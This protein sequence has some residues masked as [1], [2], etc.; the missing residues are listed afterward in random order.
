MHGPN[1]ITLHKKN[2]N[3]YPQSTI[4]DD[5]GK[6]DLGRPLKKVQNIWY[7]KQGIHQ[8]QL[9]YFTSF[10]FGGSCGKPAD[11]ELLRIIA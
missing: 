9:S 11:T 4:N 5:Y 3:Q 10:L 6:R 7:E 2:I 1:K 8:R